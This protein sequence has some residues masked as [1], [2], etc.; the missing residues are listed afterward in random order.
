MNVIKLL[1]LKV[2]LLFR[3]VS[4]FSWLDHAWFNRFAKT[5]VVSETDKVMTKLTFQCYLQIDRGVRFKSED[6]LDANAK[7]TN[8]DKQEWRELDRLTGCSIED[9]NNT[10]R[11]PN[12]SFKKLFGKQIVNAFMDAFFTPLENYISDFHAHFIRIL[13]EHNMKSLIEGYVGADHTLMQM[14]K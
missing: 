5:E 7:L 9:F 8:R 11:S 1:Y 12:S 10:N 2:G 6:P 3:H 13:S 4:V 14:V